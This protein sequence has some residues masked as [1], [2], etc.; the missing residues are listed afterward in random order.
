[1]PMGL[2]NAPAFFQRMTEDVLFTAHPELHAF[3]SV[4]MDDI[5]IAAEGE[6]LS[7]EELVALHQK[8]FHQVLDILDKNQLVC[9][10]QK[11]KL[12]LRSVESC[13]SVLANGTRRRSLGKLPAI[14]K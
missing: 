6:R 13:G 1:M 7:E 14:Q 10:P 8:Q 4:Y 12:L 9:G 11:G 3:V 2:R 5:I